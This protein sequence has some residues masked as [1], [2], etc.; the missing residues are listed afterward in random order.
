VLIQGLHHIKT[1]LKLSLRE[2]C[3]SVGKENGIFFCLTEEQEFSLVLTY[4]EQLLCAHVVL[5]MLVEV[6]GEL[7]MITNVIKMF[8]ILG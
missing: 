4:T 2:L 3:Y 6:W 7:R 1:T 8:K 5:L